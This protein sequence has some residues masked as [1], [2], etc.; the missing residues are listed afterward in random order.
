MKS[1]T[2]AVL[3]VVLAVLVL[4]GVYFDLRAVFS[5]RQLRTM[6]AQTIACQSNMNRV[7]LLL[8]EAVQY[9]KTHP[10]I[11]PVLQPFEGKPAAR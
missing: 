7:G 10:D 11:N 3:T 5:Q 2:N 4:A 6:Q 1:G 9:G 8:N